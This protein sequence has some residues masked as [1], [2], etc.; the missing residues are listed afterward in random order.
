MSEIFDFGFT[1]L[2]EDELDVVQSATQTATELEEVKLDLMA[3]EKKVEKLHAAIQPLLDNLCSNPEKAYIH[4]ADRLTK[5]EQFRN[6]LQKIV[7]E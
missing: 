4:W 5:I 2:D 7:D 1:A 6:Y 3:V